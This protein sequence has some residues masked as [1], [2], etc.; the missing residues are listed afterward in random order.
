MV[1]HPPYDCTHLAQWVRLCLSVHTWISERGTK[2]GSVTLGGEQEENTK[3]TQGAR[4]SMKIP[5]GWGFAYLPLSVACRSLP[6]SLTG[7]PVCLVPESMKVCKIHQGLSYSP[8]TARVDV[9][10]PRLSWL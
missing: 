2:G 7:A 1:L 3:G 4:E 8:I 9:K 6:A 10:L 5:G